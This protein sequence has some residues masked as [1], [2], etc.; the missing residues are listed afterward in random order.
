MTHIRRELDAFVVR[1]DVEPRILVQSGCYELDNLGD[2]S[3]LRAAIERLHERLPH[4]RFSVLSRSSAGLKSLAPGAVAVPV[5]NRKE[6]KWVRSAYLALRHAVPAADPMIRGRFPA[7]FGKLLRLKANRLVNHDALRQTDFMLLSGGG[8][9]TDV[10][11]GQAWSALERIRAASAKGIPFAIVG[12]GFGPLGDRD[13]LKVATELIPAAR[14]IALRE[15]PASLSLLEK[16]GVD[17]D[18][19]VVTGD[20]SV[21]QAWRMR[22]STPGTALGVNLRVAGYAGTTND[23][24]AAVRDALRRLIPLIHPVFIPVPVCV[25]ESVESASDTTIA[26]RLIAG[27]PAAESNTA[28]PVTVESL[29]DR[30]SHCRAI[31]TG[32]YHGAV[33]ALSQGIPAIC[34]ENSAY[35]R[36]KFEG[37][38]DQFGT[39]C[40]IVSRSD[41]AFATRLGDAVLDVWTGADEL[42]PHLLGA[43]ARQVEA[44]RRAYDVL[45]EIIADESRTAGKQPALVA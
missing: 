22:K 23:D 13:L 4:A 33:F 19:I 21:E 1:A 32:S 26:D 42:R 38:A 17:S 36:T 25:V 5:E 43:A 18:R 44:G 35:Y 27:L 7:L 20:D 8:Y 11:P 29:I 14:L 41:H 45:A 24:I 37:L 9:F 6:W 3:M 16:F 2:Q 12:H 31:V 30:I 34:V 10:F 15:R 40:R 39:G 28:A